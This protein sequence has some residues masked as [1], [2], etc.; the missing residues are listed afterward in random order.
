M[1]AARPG[2]RKPA[3]TMNEENQNQPPLETEPATADQRETGLP[4]QRRRRPRRRFPR[5]RYYDRDD[6]SEN[7][8]D[9][10]NENSRPA[11]IDPSTG[12]VSTES[13]DRQSSASVPAGEQIQE[14]PEFGE[15]IIPTSSALSPSVRSVTGLPK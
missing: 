8:N 1:A 15:G 2:E 12:E 11:V 5:R 7:S 9:S 14:E 13:L 4:D 3:L 6:R 10:N